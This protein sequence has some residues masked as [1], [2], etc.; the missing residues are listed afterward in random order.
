MIAP[1][2]GNQEHQ[3]SR[4]DHEPEAPV[5]RDYGGDVVASPVFEFILLLQI[6]DAFHF[7]FERVVGKEGEH[8]GNAYGENVFQLFFIADR[9]ERE[10]GRILCFP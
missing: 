1:S 3:R 7:A 6:L 10:A 5:C 2:S 8:T 4:T 9:E